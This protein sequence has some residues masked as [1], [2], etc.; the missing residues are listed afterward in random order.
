MIT[1]M[2]ELRDAI[3]E[4]CDFSQPL[5][6]VAYDVGK[7]AKRHSTVYVDAEYPTRFSVSEGMYSKKGVIEFTHYADGEVLMP[8]HAIEALDE[9][10][11]EAPRTTVGWVYFF[12]FPM[13]Y[14]FRLLGTRRIT[15]SLLD[16]NEV[17]KMYFHDE[18]P[19]TLIIEAD[20]EV[21]SFDQ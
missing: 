12:Y 7:K 1:T 11:T 8:E 20:Y 15:D 2:Q 18:V 13:D 3:A 4:K 19:N 10:L 14:K 9:L 16:T 6:V 17:L 5:R 21:G